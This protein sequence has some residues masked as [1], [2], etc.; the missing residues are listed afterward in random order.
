MTDVKQC[1]TPIPENRLEKKAWTRPR[2]QI[3][4]YGLTK[5]KPTSGAEG[6][7]NIGPS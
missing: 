6:G 7:T 5:G 4:S 2:L 3:L 1:A